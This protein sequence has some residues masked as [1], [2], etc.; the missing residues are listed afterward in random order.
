MKRYLA[1]TSLA[2]ALLAPSAFAQTPAPAA[3]TA[4]SA[5]APADSSAQK[6]SKVEEHIKK[7]HSALGITSAQESQFQAFAQAMRDQNQAM[8]AARE[9]KVDTDLSAPEEM[10]RYADMAQTHAD[11]IKTM[12]PSF[13]ALYDSLSDAQKKKADKLFAHVHGKKM[14]H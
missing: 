3:P 7:L 14:A 5:A 11:A 12:L 8:Y 10:Q 2:M 4:A 6:L 13:K 1:M 9:N